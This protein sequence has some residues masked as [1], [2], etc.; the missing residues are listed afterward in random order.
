MDVANAA[1]PIRWTFERKDLFLLETIHKNWSS[2]RWWR[3][4][5]ERTKLLSLHY[6]SLEDERAERDGKRLANIALALTCVTIASAVADLINLW[7][8]PN[9][10]PLQ[11]ILLALIPVAVGFLLLLW[12]L[13][14]G[15]MA[16]IAGRAHRVG[17]ERELRR[18]GWSH[19]RA[20]WP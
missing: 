10:A 14:A 4:I 17:G 16:S 12:V 1:H 8:N 20:D 13:L 6:D 9:P 15:T 5:E 7:T 19:A 3:N 11:Y 18:S 2:D